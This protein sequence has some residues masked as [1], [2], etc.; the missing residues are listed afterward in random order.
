MILR[1]TALAG[2]ESARSAPE[3]RE[4]GDRD[5]G[6]ASPPGAPVEVERPASPTPASQPRPTS[7]PS[8]RQGARDFMGVG[9]P[10]PGRRFWG[11]CTPG[12]TEK[13]AYTSPVPLE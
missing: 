12:A 4:A 5:G 9:P 13:P 11:R 7:R 2:V 6:F 8:A 3:S 10:G 1:G